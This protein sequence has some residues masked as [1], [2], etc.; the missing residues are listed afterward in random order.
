MSSSINTTGTLADQIES[1]F[2]YNL[3]MDLY[4]LAAE[5]MLYGAYTILFAFYVHILYTRAGMSRNRL[6]NYAT[7]SLF[8]FSNVH[9][10][11]L[12]TSTATTRTSVHS[13]FTDTVPSKESSTFSA[14]IANV[15]VFVY[16]TSNVL[17]D[18]IFIF[19]CYAIWNFQLKIILFPIVCTIAVAGFGYLNAGLSVISV[20]NLIKNGIP[21]DFDATLPSVF[22][23][24]AV[25]TSLGTTILLM[26]LSAGRVWWLAHISKDIMGRKTTRKYH[27]VCTMI[28]ESGTV[29]A[30]GALT[31]LILF[32]V[33]RNPQFSSGIVLE[34]LVG[35]APTIIAV[36]AGLDLPPTIAEQWQEESFLIK[37][38][39]PH[40]RLGRV[41]IF[42]RGNIGENQ[43][44]QGV[45]YLCA[46][47]D[48]DPEKATEVLEPVHI[49]V[50]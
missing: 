30:L 9:F 5:A 20:N 26:I 40:P 44:Q 2:L 48:Y 18:S 50:K 39:T 38:H 31:S 43:A 10:V 1:E 23:I 34:Q 46:E 35:I 21:D 25:S 33:G 6:L 15:A 8:A 45:I 16:V 17:A 13:V 32:L 19:R 41:P 27:T 7:I 28:L 3:Q 29:Y 24:A 37:A 11:L 36:R 47:A 42:P 12:L 49:R 4:I 22:F 14:G